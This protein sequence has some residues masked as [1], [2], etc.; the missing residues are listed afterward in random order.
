MAKLYSNKPYKKGFLRVSDGY[1]LYYEL[2]G[3]P[4]GIPVLYLHGG[5]G[6]G[7]WPKDR[8]YFNPKI[9]NAILFDQ[10]GAGKSRPFA[11]TKNN[12]TWKL[13]E[14]INALLGHLGIEK[15]FLFGGS[16]GSTLALVYAIKNP[17][18]VTGMLLRG[19]WLADRE[20]M[21]KYYMGGGAAN[22]FPDA[23][24]RLIGNVPKSMRK[25]PLPYFVRQMNS[26]NRKIRD[27]YAKEMAIYEMTMLMLDMKK[28]TV[29]K[30]L[31]R[32][33]YKSLGPLETHYISNH[34]FLEDNFILRNSKTLSRIPTVIVHG[35]YDVICRPLLAWKLHKAL[36]KSRLY[37]VIAGHSSSDKKV[38]EKLVEEMD[39]FAKVLK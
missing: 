24:E 4:K 36:P 32:G 5:P 33:T 22:H 30:Y 31:K 35:R 21:E 25:N 1:T 17:S 3:N 39:K 12:T 23:W 6:A 20:D 26:R 16:W 7:I 28:K 19:V 13:V 14:D 29:E 15:V 18:R 34:C 27:K 2:C 38:E 10:R 37:F 8:R 11:S 9:Y